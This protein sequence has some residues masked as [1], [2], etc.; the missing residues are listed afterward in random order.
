MNGDYRFRELSRNRYCPCQR[1]RM[2]S[3]MGPAVLITLGVLFLLD[4]IVGS[5]TY[6]YS[7]HYT[8][9]VLL[10]VIGVVKVLGYNASTEGHIPRGIYIPGPGVPPPPPTPGAQAPPSTPPSSSTHSDYSSTPGA[11]DPGSRGI[12]N[13]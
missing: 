5:H 13:V 6:H 2:R 12:D 10:I 7:F 8:W 9:P 11:S 4:N 1:C 3:A